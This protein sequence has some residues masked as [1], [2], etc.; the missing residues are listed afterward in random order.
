M[1]SKKQGMENKASLSGDKAYRT[2]K[3]R[4]GAGDELARL[5]IENADSE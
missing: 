4:S 5:M 2:L 1:C 3:R